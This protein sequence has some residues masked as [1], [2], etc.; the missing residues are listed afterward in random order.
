MRLVIDG[1][2]KFLGRKGETIVVKEDR[3]I[4]ARLQPQELEQVIIS[5]KGTIST[6][7]LR[8]LAEHGVDV[9]IVDFRGEVKARLSSPEMR[10]VSTRKEQYLAYGD[11]R[12]IEIAKAVVKAKLKN[13]SAV[14]QTL[15]KKRLETAPPLAEKLRSAAMEILELLPALEAL[16]GEKVEEMRERIMNIEG[17]GA[18]F[19]WEALSRIF[20]GWGFEERTGRYAHD[21]INAMLNYGYGILLGEVWRAVHY[22]GLDPYGGFLHADRPGK[23]SLVLDLMEEFRPHL[24]DKMVVGMVSKRMVS[25]E[26]FE[27]VDG[28]CQMKEKAR[29]LYLQELLGRL[30]EEVRF[31]GLRLTWGRLFFHQAR[32]LAK[33]LR[34]EL[35]K[36]EGFWQR[37]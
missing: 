21:P 9:L 10:T 3:K 25:K 37:W 35:D 30:E 8:L 24:V 36:Y 2:G 17:R 13:Q 15:A 33:F 31:E 34:G 12:G 18:Q 27:I 20:E 29:R 5:G 22:A 32:K 14:L 23:P 11:R 4:V 16:R 6:D 1:F 26:D 28:V 19:Y 7:A